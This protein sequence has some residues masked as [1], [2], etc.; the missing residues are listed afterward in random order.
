MLN[1]PTKTRENVKTNGNYFHMQVDTGSNI[2]LIPVN[3]WQDLGKSKYK[4][5]TLQ[6]KQFDRTIIKI[7][8]TFEDTFETKN[9]FEIL[10]IT[11][12]ACTK[13]NG[14]L[15][16]DVLKVDTSKL[17]NSMKS[18]EQEIG[19]LKG[20]KASI[21]LKENN[22]PRYIQARQLPIHILPIVV[23][24][25]KKRFSRVFWK[26]VTHGGAIGRHQ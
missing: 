25:L 24:K 21:R 18:E 10:P 12:M 17:V 9:R 14:L 15:G 1:T 13:D 26:R 23:S 4:K 7:L 5:S 6:P 11:V 16:A 2:T 22:H 19:L 8:G 3:F 20:Y